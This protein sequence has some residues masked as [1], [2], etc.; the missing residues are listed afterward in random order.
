M[1]WGELSR[2]E[3]INGYNGE[4][5]RLLSLFLQ[6]YAA[7]FGDAEPLYASCYKCLTDYITKFQNYQKNKPMET[8]KYK[9]LPMFEGITLFGTG[10]VITNETL[11]DEIA[12]KLLKEHPHGAKLFEFIPGEP[13]E[14]THPDI[15]PTKTKK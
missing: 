5:V 15:K 14:P 12:D 4:G 10:L 13:I 3:I 8:S 6:A 11:T 9:L 2:D 7:R 1:K